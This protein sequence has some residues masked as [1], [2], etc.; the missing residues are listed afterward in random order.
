MAGNRPADQ[1]LVVTVTVNVGGVDQGHDK[2]HCRAERG[3]TLLVAG[4]PVDPRQRHGAEADRPGDR[5]AGAQ[6]ASLHERPPLSRGARVRARGQSSGG[7]RSISKRHSVVGGYFGSAWARNGTLRWSS[8]RMVSGT[9][10]IRSH[11]NSG[12]WDTHWFPTLSPR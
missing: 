7:I 11:L 1:P 12:Y 6:S 2:S 3:E 5:A 9:I 10:R 4:G 8:A